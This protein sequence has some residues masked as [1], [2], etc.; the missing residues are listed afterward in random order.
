MK[1]IWIINHY[2]EPPGPGKYT[3]HFNFAKR[4]IKQGYKVKIFTASTIH[5]TDINF[6]QNNSKFKELK[7]DG[8]D[9]VF[10]KTCDYKGNGLKRMINMFEYFYR[11]IFVTKKFG[12]CDIIY[13]SAPHTLTWLA[14]YRIAKRCRAKLISETRDL[15]PETFIAMGKLKRNSLVAKLLYRIEN[16][17][18]R[19]SD[20]LIF[21]FPGGKEY[22]TTIGIQREH[23]YYI[24]NGIDLSLFN[25]QQKNFLYD[26]DLSKENQFNLVFA[27]ALGAANGLDRV[28]DA[29]KVLKDRKN[30][31]IQLLLFGNGNEAENLK[32]KC[33]DENIHNV[34]F[35]GRVEKAMIPSILRQ[36]DLLILS[37]AHL[38]NLFCYGLS[39]N[40]LFEYLA[41]GR[42]TLSNV[43]CGYDILEEYQ[44]GKTISNDD[45]EKFA[46][47]IL[48]FKN[49]DKEEY[50]KYCEN[51]KNA[52]KDFDFETLTDR[53][54]QVI[55]NVLDE[56]KI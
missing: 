24:N 17:I 14:A 49:M 32:Q 56:E 50:E 31:D 35:K 34:I 4:L 15:W 25:N 51:A 36:A 27:G 55:E 22:L 13:S 43:E 12:T 8:V 1:T 9:F 53:L 2:A 38:P 6:I 21:T 11:T 20:G 48:S 41:S 39:P 26:E 3:R 7:I 29:M 19:K 47:A 44:A 30:T 42:P 52:A 10:I 46:D 28:I 40:K 5:T 33:K 16:F 37:L 54:I 45:S 18:Y 23:V